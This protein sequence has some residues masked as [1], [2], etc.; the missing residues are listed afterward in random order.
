MAVFVSCLTG[1]CPVVA[2]ASA[3]GV[4]VGS[5]L[6]VV[7]DGWDVHNYSHAL[8]VLSKAKASGSGRF[9]Y[10]DPTQP[11]APHALKAYLD[12]PRVSS[13]CIL[14]ATACEQWNDG[15]ANPAVI[16]MDNIK[17]YATVPLTSHAADRLRPFVSPFQSLVRMCGHCFA[18]PR[19]VLP[20]FRLAPADGWYGVACGM[21][22]QAVDPS[23]F[24]ANVWLTSAGATAAP[25]YDM[26]HN[27]LVQLAGRKRV[28]FVAPKHY[29]SMHLYPSPH[30]SWRQCT[31]SHAC[32]GAGS[33]SF[34]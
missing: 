28:T 33:G 19:F 13:E 6:C 20:L 27:V 17:Y 31:C 16:D 32:G 26:E 25:H 21:R 34:L 8:P 23:D 12:V 15:W 5:D 29:E 30:P 14:H 7:Q 10:F 2:S 4:G 9:T 22:G 11:W 18:P 1:A 24:R 3:A